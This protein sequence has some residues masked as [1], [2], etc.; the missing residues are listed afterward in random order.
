MILQY[1][2]LDITHMNVDKNF[3]ICSIRVEESRK[4][5]DASLMLETAKCVFT[6]FILTSREDGCVKTMTQLNDTW[7]D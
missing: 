5:D 6:F 7:C 3:Q 2:R 4:N 1:V